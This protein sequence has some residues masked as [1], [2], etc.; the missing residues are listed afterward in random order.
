[1]PVD[2]STDTEI[3]TLLETL[4]VEVKSI[5]RQRLDHPNPKSYIGSGKI[6]EIAHLREQGIDTCVFADHLKP[7][8]IFNVQAVTGMDVFDRSRV[9]LQIFMQQASQKEA[10]LQVEYALLKYQIPM[11]RELIQRAKKGERAGFMA[12]GEYKITDYYRLVRTRMKNI[13]AELKKRGKN[14]ELRRRRRNRHGFFLVSLAG[15]TNAGKSSLMRALTKSQVAVDDRM[16]VTLNTTS[17]RAS[18]HILVTDTVGFIRD[19]PPELMEAFGST[20]EEIVDSQVIAIVVDISEA[21]SVVAEK[22]S[23][24]LD[25]LGELSMRQKVMDHSAQMIIV[26][27]KIDMETQPEEKA[28]AVM[29]SLGNQYK[30]SISTQVFTSVITREGISELRK[31]L[32]DMAGKSDYNTGAYS[33]HMAVE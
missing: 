2:G 20:L 28:R 6:M 32:V 33:G 8:Q 7:S 29:E 18:R 19:L 14:R 13:K 4:G 31:L 1:M 21:V 30:D 24:C 23:V 10:K 9:I 25:I 26:F 11:V 15:Y 12:G 22:L 5:V 16:F 3:I 17:R 27:N